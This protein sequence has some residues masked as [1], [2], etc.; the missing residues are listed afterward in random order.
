MENNICIVTVLL[1]IYIQEVDLEKIFQSVFASVFFGIIQP[2]LMQLYRWPEIRIFFY[3]FYNKLYNKIYRQLDSY[4]FV[5]FT[6]KVAF[7]EKQYFFLGCD[8]YS[9]KLNSKIVF[10]L[11][12]SDHS[13]EML[14]FY[15]KCFKENFIIENNNEFTDD[16]GINNNIA[17]GNNYF[18]ISNNQIYNEKKC[19]EI[20]YNLQLLKENNRKIQKIN[21][22]LKIDEDVDMLKKINSASELRDEFKYN[23]LKIKSLIDDSFKDIIG[24]L[25]L[26]NEAEVIALDLIDKIKHDKK[27]AKR[28][29]FCGFGFQNRIIY[30]YIFENNKNKN[31]WI[32][33]QNLQT[34]QFITSQKSIVFICENTINVVKNGNIRPSD[35][36]MIIISLG[37]DYINYKIAEAIQRMYEFKSITNFHIYYKCLEYLPNKLLKNKNISCFGVLEDIYKIKTLNKYLNYENIE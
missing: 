18:L 32:V 13:N 2:F 17:I 22:Y 7:V 19:Y 9:N 30:H 4:V 23:K 15:E 27:E 11:Q 10:S 28:F 31:C 33:D 35:G 21:I 20:L 6:P 16:L 12:S 36:D 1:S 14:P 8:I 3:T 37:N 5:I 26:F 29:I 34:K 25:Y 24:N